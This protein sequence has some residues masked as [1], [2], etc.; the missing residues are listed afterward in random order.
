M[1][2]LIIRSTA[3]Y[4]LSKVI[5]A[6]MID[7]A[8]NYMQINKGAKSIVLHP[9]Y[10]DLLKKKVFQRDYMDFIIDNQKVSL[11]IVADKQ[12]ILREDQITFS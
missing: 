7:A 4:T 2:E 12:D 9:K 10:A 8:I 3:I 5:P 6:L 1:G 11:K